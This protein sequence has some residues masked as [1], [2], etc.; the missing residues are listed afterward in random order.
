MP[1]SER[2]SGSITTKRQQRIQASGVGLVNEYRVFHIDDSETTGPKPAAR[3]QFEMTD[4]NNNDVNGPGPT[5]TS[6]C[7]SH[8][9][10][11]SRLAVRHGHGVRYQTVLPG[12]AGTPTYRPIMF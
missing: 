5:I 10:S 2:S 7:S 11:P 12:G 3:G 8:R 4:T 1:F 9:T 6:F